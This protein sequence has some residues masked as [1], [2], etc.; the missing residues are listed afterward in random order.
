VQGEHITGEQVEG[1][2]LKLANTTRMDAGTYTC[3]ADNGWGELANATVRMHTT[4]S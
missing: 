2:V 3:H 4:L 1:G